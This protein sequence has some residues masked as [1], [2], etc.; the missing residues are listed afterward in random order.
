MTSTKDNGRPLLKEFAASETTSEELT[1]AAALAG[2]VSAV[3][4]PLPAFEGTEAAGKDNKK[5]DASSFV[6][7][8]R[9]T[10]SGRQRAVQFPL[11]V[12]NVCHLLFLI[13]LLLL[14]PRMAWKSL[15]G[16]YSGHFNGVYGVSRV[17][18]CAPRWNTRNGL[19][20]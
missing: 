18:I 13:R 3:T 2:L 10:K 4:P 20:L 12:R 6:I 16:R 15:E 19:W 17:C 14:K 11:K 7:P 5:D 8:Q 9:F 1:A